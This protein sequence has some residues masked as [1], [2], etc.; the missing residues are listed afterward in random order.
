MG[1]RSAQAQES[2]VAVIWMG[3]RDL[4][5]WFLCP[6]DAQEECTEGGDHEPLDLIQ[7]SRQPL[8]QT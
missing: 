7:K 4:D 3:R 1:R 2:T 8:D 5:R 6:G